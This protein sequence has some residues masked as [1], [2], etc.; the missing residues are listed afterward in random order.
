MAM[1]LE[2][3]KTYVSRIIAGQDDANILLAAEDSI[4]ATIAKW[5]ALRD[6][7]FL[8][9]DNSETTAVASCVI[10]GNGVT[11]TNAT[12]GAL[13]GINVGQ[14]VTGSGVPAS[15]TVSAVT[16]TAGAGVTAITL[17]QASTPATVTL[18]FGAYIPVLAGVQQYN[19]PS[20]FNKPYTARLLT[21]TQTLEYVKLREI[22]RKVPNQTGQGVPLHYTIYNVHTFLATAQHRHLRLFGIPG[23]TDSLLLKYYRS[24]D[25]SATTIDIQDEFL[26]VFLDDARVHLLKAKAEDDPRLPI[27]AQEVSVG[28]A[29]CV[30]ADEDESEDEDVR[31]MSQMESGWTR[32]LQYDDWFIW[33]W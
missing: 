13:F 14:A 21:N 23:S 9:Q 2:A 7:T 10:A 5:N 6:W 4:K 18:T 19:L 11:V 26:Y 8:L 15:T 28:I 27:L 22:D 16:E 31:M 1:T 20:N 30:A 25:P 29:R 32:Q 24:M 12:A 33:G 17:S 3:A